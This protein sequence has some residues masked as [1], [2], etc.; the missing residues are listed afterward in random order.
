MEIE[1]IYR[2]GDVVIFRLKNAEELNSLGFKKETEV[3]LEH[4]EASG[5]AHRLKGG[6]EVMEKKGS[7]EGELYFRISDKAVLSHEEHDRM[8]LDAGMYLKVSQ[9]EYDPFADL[10]R[11]VL[12]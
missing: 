2:H 8:V 6:I 5:H 3:V 4:G 12:D 1:R 7:A 9:V 10:L 11:R